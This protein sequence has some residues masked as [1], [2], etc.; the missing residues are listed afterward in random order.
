MIVGFSQPNLQTNT[1]YYCLIPCINS[2]LAS[3]S[4]AIEIFAYQGRLEHQQE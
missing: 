3:I 2:V 4:E 1:K